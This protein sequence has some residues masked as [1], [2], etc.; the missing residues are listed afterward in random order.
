[1][2][3]G[4][5]R[6]VRGVLAE[7]RG[8][9]SET[10]DDACCGGTSYSSFCCCCCRQAWSPSFLCFMKVVAK[11][12]WLL[13]DILKGCLLRAMEGQRHTSTII[14]Q[15]V[16]RKEGLRQS[17]VGDRWGAS[18]QCL[19]LP[20]L[21]LFSPFINVHCVRPQLHVGLNRIKTRYC[22]SDERH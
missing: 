19:I 2:E 10:D 18:R 17:S 8:R 16:P 21:L 15:S 14:T 11:N 3:G 4:G 5:E 20:P 1:M 22:P 13:D 12:D 6:E 7:V 9:I